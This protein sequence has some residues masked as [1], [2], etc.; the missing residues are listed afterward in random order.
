MF[1]DPSGPITH[2]SWGKYIIDGKVHETKEKGK[3]IGAGKDIRIVNGK[4]SAWEERHGHKLTPE[5]ITGISK[6]DAEILI[7]G[8]GVNG[9]IKVPKE[10]RKVIN[11]LGIP[12]LILAPTPEACRRYNQLVREGRRVALLAHGTC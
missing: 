7:I 1:D 8:I 11:K 9:L 3:E 6:E 2:F 5:M 4:V 10:T 12:E